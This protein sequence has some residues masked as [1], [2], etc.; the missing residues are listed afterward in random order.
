MIGAR[1]KTLR[2]SVYILL[3]DHSGADPMSTQLFRYTYT[4]SQRASHAAS[5]VITL[6]YKRLTFVRN[7]IIFHE[8]LICLALRFESDAIFYE[9]AF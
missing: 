9:F 1:A 2:D 4:F 8:S 3:K 5:C 7:F 6:F